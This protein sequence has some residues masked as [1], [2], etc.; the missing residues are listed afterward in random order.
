METAGKPRWNWPTLHERLNNR[1]YKLVILDLALPDLDT[2][3]DSW[4][5]R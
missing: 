3:M 4:S 1:L 2:D 5:R